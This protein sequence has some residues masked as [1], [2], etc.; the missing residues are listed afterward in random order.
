MCIAAAPRGVVHGPCCGHHTWPLLTPCL[1][2]VQ[3]MFGAHQHCH[4]LATRLWL[5]VLYIKL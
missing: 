1:I 3:L 2:P 4:R 5:A